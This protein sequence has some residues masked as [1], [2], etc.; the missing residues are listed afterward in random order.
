M[1]R[2]QEG[3]E[4][5]STK[6]NDVITEALPDLPEPPDYPDA[7]AGM[8]RIVLYLDPLGG[9]VA[10]EGKSLYDD[11]RLVAYLTKRRRLAV[12]DVDREELH[13]YESFE[14]L[15]NT[16]GVSDHRMVELIVAVAA[17]LGETYV[18]ELD[19]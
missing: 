6:Q 13:Q 1:H 17:A 12:Y 16:E 3:F 14:D 2:Q 11:G 8:A 18:V 15:A 5:T 4:M 19:I 9:R 7:E 10:F